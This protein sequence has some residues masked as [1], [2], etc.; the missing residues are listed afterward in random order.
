MAVWREQVSRSHPN[1]SLSLSTV[2]EAVNTDEQND[3]TDPDSLSLYLWRQGEWEGICRLMRLETTF[4]G[5]SESIK[6]PETHI[7]HDRVLCFL[8]LA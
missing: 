6:C 1:D 5:G 3:T 2:A 8:S 4:C 7:M